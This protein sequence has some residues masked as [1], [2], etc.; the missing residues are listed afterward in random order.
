MPRIHG[1]LGVATL[2][3]ASLF[4][5]VSPR[6]EGPSVEL[7]GSVAAN[8]TD[9]AIT[10]SSITGPSITGAAD[11]A[12]FQGETHGSEFSLVFRVPE[13]NY[14]LEAG[15][16]EIFFDRIADRIFSARVDGKAWLTR[17]DVFSAAGGRNRAIT[18][19]LDVRAGAGGLRVDFDSQVNRAKFSYLRLSGE[20][21]REPILVRG[22]DLRTTGATL[23]RVVHELLPS[24]PAGFEVSVVAQDPDIAFPTVIAPAPPLADGRGILYVAEDNYNGTVEAP[25]ARGDLDR[26]L[27][28]E[29]DPATGKM[30]RA[31]EFARGFGSIQGLCWVSGRLLVAAAPEVVSLRDTNDDGVADERE[32][33]LTDCGPAP[34]L[35]GLRHHLPSGLERAVDG[36][37]VL[38]I[39]DHGCRAANRFGERVVLEGGGSL[40]FEPDGRGLE[41]F[42]RGLRN[43]LHH[44]ESEWGEWF[45]RDNTNDGDGWDS[46]LFHLIPGGDYGYPFLFKRH[47]DEVLKPIGEYGGGSSTGNTIYREATFPKEY[48][49]RLF[50]ADWGKREV[51]AIRLEANGATFTPRVERFL[52]QKE[53]G[54]R[55][56][57]PTGMAVDA[58]GDLLV[59]DWARDGW[60]ESPRVG[61]I[62]RVRATGAAPP[63]IPPMDTW[64]RA[65]AA[66]DDPRRSVR[67]AA[68]EVL[69]ASR[70]PNAVKGVL[71][72]L[73]GR[74]AMKDAP[75]LAK[76]HLIWVARRMLGSDAAR[77]LCDALRDRNDLVAAQAARAITG[78]GGDRT[79]KA[80]E[81]AL[82]M[83]RPFTRCEAAI[84]LGKLGSDVGEELAKHLMDPDPT[85]A[86]A[87]REAIRASGRFDSVTRWFD[88]E[89]EDGAIAA[90][91]VCTDVHDGLVVKRLCDAA[92]NG[93]T[94]A[95]RAKAIDSLGR[96]ALV[97][98]PW[99]GVDWWGTQP[100]TP[101]RKIH[102]W[103]GSG[104][105]LAAI[106]EACGSGDSRAATAALGAA[107]ESPDPSLAMPLFRSIG[108]RKAAERERVVR[109]LASVATPESAEALLAIAKDPNSGDDL[110]AAALRGLR[111]RAGEWVGAVCELAK[112]PAAALRAAACEAL[113][114]R[115]EEPAHTALRESLG[116]KDRAVRLAAL[117]AYQNTKDPTALPALLA[118]LVDPNESVR[119]AAALAVDWNANE[120]SAEVE[121]AAAAALGDPALRGT[122]VRVLEK[123]GSA[124]ALPALLRLA[125]AESQE[126]ASL[127]GAALAAC[128]KLAPKG[129]PDAGADDAALDRWCAWGAAHIPNFVEPPRAAAGEERARN[130]RLAKAA[131]DRPGDAFRGRALFFDPAGPRCY[132]CHQVGKEGEKVGPDL[133]DVGA[134]YGKRFLV[135][136]I[137]EPS[138][139]IHGGFEAA[140]FELEGGR[141]L[142]GTVVGE[143]QDS[144]D[145]VTG[146]GARESLPKN[147]IRTRG[148]QAISPMPSG[149]AAALDEEK[150]TD[151]VAYLASLR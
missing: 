66:L 68:S 102:R 8:R 45:T 109:W 40:R 75:P 128:A 110:R 43:T 58:R 99:N 29:L 57:R 64:Q 125:A 126:S 148:T 138:R 24:A 84:T 33:I 76:I 147:K 100:K 11:P 98:D 108:A 106:A 32:A 70:D 107:E 3:L 111:G 113:C 31:T 27:R 10:V 131:L 141:Q 136:S 93:K 74:G 105:A 77:D 5:W 28:L 81:A 37:V 53:G 120:T 35:F 42:T 97:A 50:A 51:Y 54:V 142:S 6:Q 114:E 96:V 21:L 145:V 12:L 115:G 132:A 85:V 88:S 119:A 67:D 121:G 146:P 118:A 13:G 2:S 9:S 151:L 17:L 82:A 78:L 23:T 117:A 133:T 41:V 94:A 7:E 87:V 72:A 123:V 59:A 39:G 4:V 55:D 49:G 48:W 73:S 83:G 65:L 135:E 36:R 34:A 90:I 124:A 15:F 101:R 122:M 112:N 22:G 92:R 139:A 130:E 137:L 52:Q 104:E 63:P 69:L 19:E 25:G 86:W 140:V 26:V 134:K 60:A 47:P 1:L 116:D 20:A 129:A 44:S 144:V 71:A 91:R 18:R 89:S 16:A 30:L 79:Q 38:S 127:R 61:R 95:V 46:R 143:S 62:L 149:L 150:F 56:F 103:D 14:R 80:L